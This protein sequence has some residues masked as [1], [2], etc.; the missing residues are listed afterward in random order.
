MTLWRPSNGQWTSPT[1]ARV[2]DHE[3]AAFLGEQSRVQSPVAA[4]IAMGCVTRS[5]AGTRLDIEH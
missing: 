1:D 5:P 2:H 4:T 3:R